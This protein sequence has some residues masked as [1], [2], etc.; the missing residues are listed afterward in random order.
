MDGNA[1]ATTTEDHPDFFRYHLAFGSR[2]FSCMWTAGF[3]RRAG[4]GKWYAEIISSYAISG[5]EFRIHHYEKIPSYGKNPDFTFK[6]NREFDY[7]PFLN[8]GY[9]WYLGSTKVKMEKDNQDIQE[10]PVHVKP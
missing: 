9:V 7:F 2:D 1:A 4:K 6:G 8:L 3:E 10:C 5:T